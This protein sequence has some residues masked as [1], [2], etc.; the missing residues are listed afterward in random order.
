MPPRNRKPPE[1]PPQGP[2]PGG[3]TGPEEA[4]DG[5]RAYIRQ[6]LSRGVGAEIDSRM[7]GL[8]QRLQAS[9]DAGIAG[10]SEKINSGLQ[11]GLA[12]IRGVVPDTAA[13]A[14]QVKQSILQE[15]TAARA[16]AQGGAAAASSLP[17]QQAASP[18]TVVNVGGGQPA[19]GQQAMQITLSA[20]ELAQIPPLLRFALPMINNFG[21]EI[22]K[23]VAQGIA[24]KMFGSPAPDLAIDSFDPSKLSMAHIR[25][26]ATN[27]ASKDLFFYVADD[28]APNPIYEQIPRMQKETW[29]QATKTAL[30]FVRPYLRMNG[31]PES[32][33]GTLTEDSVAP[34]PD[35]SQQEFLLTRT[36]RPAASSGSS[37]NGAG[38]ADL[39]STKPAARPTQPIRATALLRRNGAA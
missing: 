23:G 26:I 35:F 27:D 18:S 38:S 28:L 14:Q 31:V 7:G 13:I 1:E 19:A 30:Q 29:D 34:S 5:V 36:R 20:E 25:K 6:E 11:N 12:E 4:G 3:E 2:P 9:I 21:G 33:I 8:E 17:A 37:T 16:S 10:I 22:S 32:V 15:A 39:R 24:H